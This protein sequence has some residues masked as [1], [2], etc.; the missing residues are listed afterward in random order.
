MY[1]METNA[2][3]RVGVQP[4]LLDTDDDALDMSW[5]E[6]Q[7]KLNNIETIYN[8]EPIKSINLFFIYVNK[9]QNVDEIIKEKHVLQQPGSLLSKEI[10]LQYIQSKKR[11]S[12][13]SKYKF[14]DI[15][16]YNVDI[17]PEHIQA[18]STTEITVE[19]SSQYLKVL[20]FSAD[21][22]V[23]DAIFVFHETT[24]LFFIFQEIVL[25]QS[26]RTTLKSILK[27]D[28]PQLKQT[29]KVRIDDNPKYTRKVKENLNQS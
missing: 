2:S 29:K 3:S 21:I 23:A 13:K 10:L 20:P 27:K 26:I 14:Q 16:V 17:E 4:S 6:E 11:L 19:N 24:A 5:L 15:A 12:D 22:H 25:N 8:R 1:K 7:E 18:Y 9:D 28:K